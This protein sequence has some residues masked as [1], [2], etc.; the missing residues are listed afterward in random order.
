MKSLFLLILSAL[1]ISL[2]MQSSEK[3]PLV[4]KRIVN[5]VRRL[6]NPQTTIGYGTRYINNNIQHQIRKNDEIINSQPSSLR[7]LNGLQ[8]NSQQFKDI[9]KGYL[10]QL[11]QTAKNEL[12]NKETE[13]NTKLN[14][15]QIDNL[16]NEIGP[17]YINNNGQHQVVQQTDSAYTNSVNEQ[18]QES[19]S[20]TIDNSQ[21]EKNDGS[22]N[23]DQSHQ[24]NN[25]YQ[26]ISS[27]NILSETKP[28][29]LN[30][31]QPVQMV[32][33][34]YTGDPHLDQL[35][36]DAMKNHTPGTPIIIV[37]KVP[38]SQQHNQ[39][40]NSN[41]ILTGTHQN[42]QMVDSNDVSHKD[43]DLLL[44][45]LQ[46]INDLYA[47][48]FKD[49][50]TQ[51]INGTSGREQV[52]QLLTFYRKVSM[53]VKAAAEKKDILKS[54]LDKLYLKVNNIKT[55]FLN[56]LNFYSAHD[57]YNK[58]K[59]SAESYSK[60]DP[61]Y[62]DHFKV[63]NDIVLNFGV[64]HETLVT[65]AKNLYSL[66]EYFI[67]KLT[68]LKNIL[69]TGTFKDVLND[70]DKAIQSLIKLIEMKLNIE[71]A[72]KNIKDS[73]TNMKEYKDPLD[74]NIKDID[75]L[76]EYH[77]MEKATPLSLDSGSVRQTIYV[78][79]VAFVLSRYY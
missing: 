77:S 79:G 72:L 32:N 78:V 54:E 53:F 49:L 76:N 35:I 37:N 19:S 55:G 34:Y 15:Q 8:V 17:K 29:T 60:E 10:S 28:A 58:V 24:V 48:N 70:F 56:V 47:G 65:S 2:R 27:S 25:N 7:Q 36:A 61:K 68:K 12:A 26:T 38:N 39:L 20:I 59:T 52:T 46:N 22:I 23:I 18:G 74:K 69:G 73:L 41:G 30:G 21:I 66:T 75:M 42:G 13:L 31:Q 50:P 64:Q 1:Y 33:Q 3:T 62:L 57:A 51:E 45:L 67:D 14:I 6:Q 63:I 11:G 43:I 16:A 40:I 9:A 44:N 5:T 71:V 4:R